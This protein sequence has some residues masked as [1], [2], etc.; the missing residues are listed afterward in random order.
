MKKAEDDN[1]LIVRLYEAHGCRGQ[2]TFRTSLPVKRVIETDLMENEEKR[3]TLRNGAVRM[4]FA[5]FQI[6]TIKLRVP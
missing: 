1:G 2:R 6:R 5:P 3:L 4:F